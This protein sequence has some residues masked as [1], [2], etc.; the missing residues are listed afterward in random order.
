MTGPLAAVR[1]FFVAPPVHARAATG[2]AATVA[3][4]FAVLGERREALAVASGLV[5]ASGVGPGL[6]CVWPA[7]DVRP[8]LP[9]TA[10][11]RRLV[12]RLEARGV[13]ALAGGRLVGVP[14][15]GPAAE[16]V[17]TSQRAVAAVDVTTA[18]VL[19]GPRDDD[20][21]TLLALQDAVVLVTARAADSP[22]VRLAVAG[23]A[24]TAAPVV[25]VPAPSGPVRALASAGLVALPALRAALGPALT[26]RQP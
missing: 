16:A 5:L 18:V 19:A 22:L 17:A 14:L 23:L 4:S 2:R 8:R 6:V 7:G 13:T 11:A 25:T 3:P 10:R 24:E 15:P 20:L 1:E 12:A 21:D 9:A 26:A